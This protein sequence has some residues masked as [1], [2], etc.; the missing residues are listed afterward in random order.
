MTADGSG[1]MAI[2]AASGK[3]KPTIWR[4]QERYMHDGADG[5]VRVEGEQLVPKLDHQLVAKRVQRLGPVQADE[6]HRAMS[7]DQDHLGHA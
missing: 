1:T 4:W 2:A 3:S 5:L 7:L 6:P